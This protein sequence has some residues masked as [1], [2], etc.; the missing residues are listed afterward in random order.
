MEVNQRYL[1]V[2][3]GVE[4]IPLLHVALPVS[5]VSRPVSIVEHSKALP[6]S[7]FPKAFIAISHKLSLTFRLQPNV[8]TPSFLLVVLPIPYI[9]LPDVCPVHGPHAALH[10]L[11]PLSFEKVARRV[12]V[13]LT[14][15]VLHVVLE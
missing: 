6:D 12:I 5:F 1:S 15:A 14:V 4:R 8:N 11:L 10:V 3:V 7:C 9:F 13:H 2:L